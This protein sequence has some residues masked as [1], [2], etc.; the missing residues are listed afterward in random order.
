[1]SMFNHPT[2]CGCG[3][4]EAEYCLTCAG[5][6]EIKREPSRRSRNDTSPNLLLILIIISLGISLCV[7]QL[8]E[9]K[10][11]DMGGVSA[12]EEEQQLS[13]RFL[14]T[15]DPYAGVFHEP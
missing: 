2:I 5:S 10:I 11:L 13:D 12:G 1:M 7:S 14:Y 9:V 8:K 3:S 4:G 15:E 6:V